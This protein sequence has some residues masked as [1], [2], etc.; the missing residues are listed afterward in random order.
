MEEKPSDG[1]S[2]AKAAPASNEA[3]SPADQNT[4]QGAAGPRGSESSAAAAMAPPAIRSLES[5]AAEPLRTHRTWTPK[6]GRV[7]K[8]DWCNGRSEGTLQVCSGCSL[9][10]CE[11]CARD[12][13]WQTD[14]TH[15]ID[16]DACDW[17]VRKA[18][19]AAPTKRGSKRP[20]PPSPK[21]ESAAPAARRR[22]MDENGDDEDDIPGP[23]PRRRQLPAPTNPAPQDAGRSVHPPLTEE[24]LLRHQAAMAQLP[25]QYPPQLSLAPRT[26][27]NPRQAASTAMLGMNEPSRRSS[28][29]RFD[30][31]GDEYV[32]NEHDDDDDAE[33][34]DVYE[35]RGH[36]GNVN[37]TTRR[38]S[39]RLAQNTAT[40]V[41]ARP[42]TGARTS[43]NNTA[44]PQVGAARPHPSVERSP[45]TSDDRDRDG[46]V[47]DIYEWIYGNRPDLDPRRARTQ[48]PER[49][50]N[51][52]QTAGPQYHHG[53]SPAPHHPGH[54][55]GQHPGAPQSA[56]TQSHPQHPQH[57]PAP[58]GYS[59]YAVRN[60]QEHAHNPSHNPGGPYTATSRT[61]PAYHPYNNHTAAEIALLQQDRQTLDEM[62]HAWTHNPRLQRLA[63]QEN[64]RVHALGLL[65]DVFELRRTA[66]VLVR[67]N[68]LTVGWFV[69]ERET[70]SRL[71]YDIAQAAVAHAAV[72]QAAARA[73]RAVASP[74][75][76]QQQQAHA[77]HHQQ[78]QQQAQA[79]AHQ[80]WGSRGGEGGGGSREEPDDAAAAARSE[81][82][83]IDA[84]AG[85]TEDGD[86][87]VEE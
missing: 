74:R 20:A 55:Y 22:K 59:H 44:S 87:T 37:N 3:P 8:C 14:H 67:D 68:S 80:A 62:H 49:W 29:R 75:V 38:R 24:S 26:R 34:D 86:E 79:Q 33:G 6:Y 36:A 83:T 10:I 11:H 39:N 64:R 47:L 19:R 41:S 40:A 35:E 70:Q 76:Q 46:A 32:D 69:A 5:L 42:L 31:D 61:T 66:R 58:P 28:R 21:K 54:G 1:G 9:R 17:V 71:E 53:P 43:R 63:G 12:R 60:Y 23:N 57:P 81:N 51:D 30:D 13:T 84:N 52:W 56:A 50:G 4:P 78:A 65:W 85:D 18:P 77:R 27:P 48:I 15:F 82:G 72:A 2:T 73:V 16:V 7:Q 25:P 45:L